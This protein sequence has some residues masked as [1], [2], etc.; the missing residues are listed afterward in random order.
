MNWS[1]KI[2]TP[3]EFLEEF[4]VKPEEIDPVV[5]I[6]TFVASLRVVTAIK[7]N[8]IAM[9]DDR[10][11]LGKLHCIMDSSSLE[12]N[13]TKVTASIDPGE[14]DYSECKTE[15]E[16]TIHLAKYS[17]QRFLWESDKNLKEA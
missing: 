15:E 7:T 1:Y 10:S 2:F 14:L 16:R 9:D 17:R 13:K 12:T 3:E 6:P 11:D 5:G 4:P 8:S